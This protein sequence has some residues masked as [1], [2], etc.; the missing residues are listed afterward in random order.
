MSGC[1]G[2]AVTAHL[3]SALNGCITNTVAYAPDLSGATFYAFFG[4]IG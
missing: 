1:R 4:S 2:Q 3:M